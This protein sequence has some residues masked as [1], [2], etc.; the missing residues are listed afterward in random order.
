MKDIALFLVTEG[1]F[2]KAVLPKRLLEDLVVTLKEK[3]KTD[4]HFSDKTILVEGI[5]IP[6][7]D[8]QTK[9]MA[10]SGSEDAAISLTK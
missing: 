10:I 3:G 8:S 1:T 7:K 2:H 4:V 9:L 6:A 5:Y